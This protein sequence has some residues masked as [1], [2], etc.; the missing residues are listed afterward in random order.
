V[1]LEDAPAAAGTPA[2]RPE[3][4]APVRSGCAS[5]I[6]HGYANAMFRL[7]TRYEFR[8]NTDEA[9][10]CYGKASQLGNEPAQARLLEI[11]MARVAEADDAAPFPSA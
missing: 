8:H 2:L 1:K 11:P 6:L 7:G 3:F 5:V 10:R 4:S 9:V